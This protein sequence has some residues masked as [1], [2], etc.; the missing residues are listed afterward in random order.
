M[1]CTGY[2]EIDHNPISGF[3]SRR[4]LGSL[5]IHITI[6]KE[7]VYTCTFNLVQVQECNEAM[8]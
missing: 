1:A 8:F 4:N 7:Q 5:K 6:C 3:K 2:S